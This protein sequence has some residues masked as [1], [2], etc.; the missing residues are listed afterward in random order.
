MK[1]MMNLTHM[2][3]RKLTQEPSAKVRGMLA[4]KLAMDYRSGN[5]TETEAEIADDI[6]RIL[7][8]DVERKVRQT[9]SEQ[10]CHCPH[11]PHDIVMKLANDEGEIAVPVLRH[12]HVLTDDDLLAI[13]QST[14]EVAKLCAVARRDSVSEKVSASL[15]V[16]RSERVLNELFHNQGAALPET[17]LAEAWES[18]AASPSLLE[19]LVHR[20]GLPITVAEKL[21]FSVSEDLKRKLAQTYK[22][23]TPLIHKAAGDSREWEM[24]GIIPE[25]MSGDP[26]SDEQVEDL[27]DQLYLGGRLTHSLLIRALCTGNLNVFEA[28]MARLAGVPRV[29][30]RLLLMDNGGLGFRAIYQTAAM[31]EGFA[32]AVWALL[33]IS[34]EETDYGLHK[35]TDFRKRIIDRIYMEGLH[36]K[37]DNMEYLLSIIG[38]KN[39]PTSVH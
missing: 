13:I 2:D 27:I 37:V 21:F 5:F 24:L 29:N 34:L 35:R 9:L 10:L 32:D 28:G 7:L 11:V 39:A 31:P 36:R 26:N 23:S 8:K 25:G 15:L 18:I 12:S 19:T 1:Q 14:H 3:V 38:G 17:G 20:G 22:L 30:A 33:K 4:A 16:T 6:F